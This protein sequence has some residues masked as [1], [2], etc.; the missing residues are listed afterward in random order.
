MVKRIEFDQNTVYDLSDP[1]Q[2]TASARRN[3][4]LKRNRGVKSWKVICR[5]FR[6]DYIDYENGYGDYWTE[7]QEID[8]W[9]F[10]WGLS[11]EKAIEEAKRLN[12]LYQRE[13]HNNDALRERYK[14]TLNAFYAMATNPFGDD[15]FHSVKPD[16]EGK[17]YMGVS[18][19]YSIEPNEP[20]R[21][22]KQFQFVERYPQ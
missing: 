8:E 15:N 1:D 5:V 9:D 17:D 7:D 19:E 10:G 14:G 11:K 4:H 2:R 12:E 3:T 13:R 6:K 16:P 21:G 18:V 20:S 22:E